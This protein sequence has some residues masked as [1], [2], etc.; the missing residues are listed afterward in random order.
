L[1]TDPKT[2][3]NRDRTSL[4]TPQADESVMEPSAV[5]PAPFGLAAV[6]G[7]AALFA[8]V[9]LLS[10]GVSFALL[11][12][13]TRYLTPAE[14]GQIELIEL[15]FDV[16]TMIAGSRLLGGLF[17]FYY[18]SDNE[19]ERRA[20]ISTGSLIICGGYAV[21]GLAAFIGAPQ[22][23]HLCLGDTKY[24][25]LVRIGSLALASQALGTVPLALLRLQ[26][27]FHIAVAIQ[28]ARLAVQVALNVLFLVHF[29]LG[30]RA[31]FLST[32]VANVAVGGTT[33]VICMLPVGLRY[34]RA[35]VVELYRFG[36]PLIVMQAATFI[37]TFGDRY[38]LRPATSLTTVGLYAMAYNFAFAFGVLTQ[39]PFNLV[40]EP[41]R[42]E[43]AERPDRDAI[44]ARVF[45]YFNVAALAGALAIA[46]FVRDFLHIIATPP[47]YG[48]ADVVPVLLISII[49]GGWASQ[50]EVGIL[51]AE[52]TGF[53]AAANW[54]A[55]G[56]T[57]VAYA[58]LIPR[59][60]SWGAAIATVIGYMVRELAT[61]KFSQ[62][63]LPVRYTWAP[64][65]KLVGITLATY[66]LSRLIP[67]GPMVYMLPARVALY[68]VYLFV[69]WRSSV[70]SD[71]D[72][73]AARE[74][75]G[76]LIDRA[77]TVLGMRSL[78]PVPATERGT[79]AGN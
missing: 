66:G 75:A 73:T 52:R 76:D 14:Y 70:L 44:Y 22:L 78:A 69:V 21:V 7:F 48:A 63:V 46:V 68:V 39:T 3:L 31:I 30:P 19:D 72:R 41:K 79:D 47:F 77:A 29:H 64:V 5:M 71:A 26:A 8:L 55:A 54:L 35:I 59:Y 51:V 28:V 33:M 74:M 27:R 16:L 57:L 4:E 61:Y 15:S 37:L 50:H 67:S 17:R 62:H 32:L 23:A 65:W 24:A 11:P 36:F 58:V 40:W 60:G 45:V 13:Y 6:G 34:S 42:F 56:M 18:K 2:E 43:A 9:A 25:P 12:V 20:V 10:K 53:L 49:L 1:S 38:F